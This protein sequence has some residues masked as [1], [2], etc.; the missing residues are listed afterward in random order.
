MKKLKNG[1]HS[2]TYSVIPDYFKSDGDYQDWCDEWEKWEG[3]ESQ[4]DNEVQENGNQINQAVTDGTEGRLPEEQVQAIFQGI[5][6][7]KRKDG[8]TV[9]QQKR[10]RKKAMKM[11]QR[12][13]QNCEPDCKDKDC[14]N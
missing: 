6:K 2:S 5:F 7:Q 3:K 10:E 4:N 12:F 13:S 11:M 14:R 9:N 8:K 1:T